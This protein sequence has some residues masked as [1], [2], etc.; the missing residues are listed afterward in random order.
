MPHLAMK[1]EKRYTYSDYMTRPDEECWEIINGIPYAMSPAPNRKHQAMAGE[2]YLQL[3]F[4]SKEQA[5]PAKSIL[6]LLTYG[7]LRAVKLMAKLK[8]LSSLTLLSSVT[9]V[10]LTTKAAKVHRI[11]LSKLPPPRYWTGSGL[12]ICDFGQEQLARADSN[13][14]LM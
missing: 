11:W 12:A 5:A 6:R 4:Y 10:S 14:R 9:T 7:C 3:Q 1:V 8:R 2:L 13:G